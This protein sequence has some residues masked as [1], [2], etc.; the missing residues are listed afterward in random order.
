MVRKLPFIMSAIL[1]RR[2]WSRAMARRELKSSLQARSA[3]VQSAGTS[4]N[5]KHSVPSLVL[6]YPSGHRHSGRRVHSKNNLQLTFEPFKWQGCGNK[7][8]IGFRTICDVF[9]AFDQTVNRRLTG[10]GSLS[11]LVSVHLNRHLLER[12][13]STRTERPK[14]AKITLL[15]H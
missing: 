10:V 4:A 3:S 14:L 11:V 9:D 8:D 1:V 2:A 15:F 5:F 6:K 7:N 13:V 12:L